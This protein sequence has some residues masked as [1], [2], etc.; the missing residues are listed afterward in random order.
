MALLFLSLAERAA[1]WRR[2]FADAGEEIVIGAEAVTDPGAVTHVLCWQPP[3]DLGRYPNLQ[4]VIGVGAGVDQIGA[5][6]PGV[7]LARTLAPGIDEMV[8]DWIVMAALMLHRE[9]PRYLDQAARGDW[10]A[11]ASRPAVLTRVG[12]MGLGRIGRRAAQALAGLG[13]PVAG[14]SRSGRPVDGIEVYGA[15]RR[16]AFLARTDLLVCTLPLTPET[17]GLMDAAFFEGLPRGARLV[18][19]GRGAQLDMAALKGAL[20]SGRIA[21][22]MLDVTEPEPLPPG[23][24]AWTDPR[25]VITPHVAS[26]TDPEEG[27]RHALAVIRAGRAGVE[28]PGLVDLGRGY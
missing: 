22:A 25:V 2:V 18:Q 24:W 9:M 20:D 19:A 21:A 12:V 1:V 15:G 11:H 8:R 26:H 5:L 13:F 27:A 6:P 28:I 14:W 7:A 17:R 4:V 23:H 10:R 16:D 3:A